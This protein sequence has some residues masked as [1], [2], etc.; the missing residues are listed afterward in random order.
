MTKKQTNKKPKATE[1]L[2][3][4]PL[5]PLRDRVLLEPLAVEE[6]TAGGLF[7]P[8]NAKEK[9]LK[10][11]VIA[12]GGD[13]TAPGSLHPGAMVLFSKYSGTEIKVAGV[14]YILV[15]EEDILAA[16]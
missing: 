11:K 12:R 2:V 4:L 8:E 5:K 10:G 3:A 14:D 7:I 6:K 16:F 1:N 13:V 9:P 15:R